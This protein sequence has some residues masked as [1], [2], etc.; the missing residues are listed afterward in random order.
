MLTWS[1]ETFD[2]VVTDSFYQ[3]KNPYVNSRV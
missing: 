1:W 2:A 3:E